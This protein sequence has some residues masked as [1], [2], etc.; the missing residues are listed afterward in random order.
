M[1]NAG[2]INHFPRRK[3]ER[4]DHQFQVLTYEMRDAPERQQTLRNI[5]EWSY[6]LVKP[7]EQQLFRFLSVF[8]GGCT[9]QAIESTWELA[10]YPQEKEHI[11]EG[12]VSLLENS[13]LFRSMQDTEKPR[14]CLL[15]TIRVYGLQSL[16]LNGEQ[17]RVQ[18]AHAAYSVALAK[19]AEPQSPRP[20]PWMDRLQQEH[21]NL[22]EALCFLI[23]C[24]GDEADKANATSC[25]EWNIDSTNN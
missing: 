1:N 9:L 11:L 5:L 18:W 21:D 19:R 13:M 17:K 15:K 10:G 16:V 24:K 12:M 25:L 8:V 23:A 2:K 20:L 7:D 14:F 4:L 3:L 6:R 22:R